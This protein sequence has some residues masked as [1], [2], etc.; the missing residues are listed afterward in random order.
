MPT[1]TVNVR[2]RGGGRVRGGLAVD[3]GFFRLEIDTDA[4][5]DL[6]RPFLEQI[7]REARDEAFNL[8]AHRTGEMRDSIE[9]G[10]RGRGEKTEAFVSVGSD[11]WQ[12]VEYGTGRRGSRSNPQGIISQGYT[13]GVGEGT[14]ARPF[15][16][17]ALLSMR[18]KVQRA[19]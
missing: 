15:M 8:A 13:H 5:A 12:F 19:G 18:N 10:V 2:L 17:P 9:H 4:V 3:Q 1:K 11:H 16:R 7:A 6:S 14:P